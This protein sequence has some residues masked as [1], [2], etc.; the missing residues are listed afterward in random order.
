MI[1]STGDTIMNFRTSIL[2]GFAAFLSAG[3]LIASP[4]L[5]EDSQHRQELDRQSRAEGLSTTAVELLIRA[6]GKGAAPTAERLIK[7]FS[8]PL[9]GLSTAG[10]A[11]TDE[12]SD[13]LRVEGAAG[14]TLFVYG[15]GTQVK[16]R[17]RAFYEAHRA[18]IPASEKPSM[19][20]L[21]ER[22]R[23]FIEKHLASEIQLGKGE[24]LEV[25][26][27]AYE[28]QGHRST[29][30][31]AEA[32]EAMTSSIVVFTRVVN[33]ID[34]VG[35][36][37]KVSMLFTSDG[38][39]FGFEYDWA[40][41]EPANRSQK[42]LDIEQLQERARSLDEGR[43]AASA[44][45]RVKRWECGYFDAGARKR[46]PNALVQAA[47]VA[48]KEVDAVADVAR[49]RA[50]PADGLVSSATVDVIP[51]GVALED[52]ARWPEARKLRGA[53]P[54]PAARPLSIV[55]TE[56][57]GDP[58]S[59]EASNAASDVD[60]AVDTAVD[61]AQAGCSLHPVG[62]AGNSSLWWTVGLGVAVVV[63]A[64]RRRLSSRRSRVRLLCD[65]R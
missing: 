4:V 29:E 59:D 57:L 44:T 26:K 30:P 1:P 58:A 65:E 42:V 23:A 31:G 20:T 51:A 18:A 50:N 16:Y 15:D 46:D 39:V 35:P 52:D 9:S 38:Q 11:A 63:T 56:A 10:E 28:M 6:R 17:N 25:L 53:A 61:A 40:A 41:Y 19:A 5:A 36:G 64:R 60:T 2:T 13:H 37:S 8:T 32:V 3:V 33:G 27:T 54:I 34:V 45:V 7:R 48:H 22:G 21:E 49:H 12:L 47:C 43:T 14:W 55:A 62:S 24:S